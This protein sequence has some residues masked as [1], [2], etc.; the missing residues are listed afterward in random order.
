MKFY[1]INT[2]F[3]IELLDLIDVKEKYDFQHFYFVYF[4][5]ADN[6]QQQHQQNNSIPNRWN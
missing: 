3:P 4:F 5:P 2:E 1:E 6:R